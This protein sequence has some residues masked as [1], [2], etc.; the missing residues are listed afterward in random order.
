MRV[1]V[2]VKR[3]SFSWQVFKVS[4]LHGTP[5]SLLHNINYICFRPDGV[6]AIAKL[7]RELAIVDGVDDGGEAVG[8]MLL[9]LLLLLFVLRLGVDGC[10]IIIIGS[11]PNGTE[12]E[13]AWKWN[14]PN[15]D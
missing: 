7:S 13:E 4:F 5:Y 6:G 14:P 2:E 15:N 8:M 1:C 12:E 9:L 3:F 11:G 10:G